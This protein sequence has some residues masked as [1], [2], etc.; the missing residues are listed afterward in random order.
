MRTCAP[1]TRAVRR[2]SRCPASGAASSSCR[3]T[4]CT[5]WPP[6]RAMPTRCTRCI[7]AKGRP[8]GMH[9][10]VLA[11]VVEQ[12]RALGVA[13]TPAARVLAR[14]WWPGPLTLA[15][16]FDPASERPAWLA[17]RDEVAVR[18]PDHD[19]LRSLLARTGVLVVT[20]ANP[21]GAPTPRTAARRGGEPRA[22]RR[23]GRR[24]RPA[25]GRPL[26]AGQRARARC[27]GGARGRDL[28][29]AEVAG[30][31][32]PRR[33][34]AGC[35]W[36]SRPRATRRPRPS[37]TTPSRCA[38]RWWRARS[39]CT[40]RSAASCPSWPAGPTSRRSPRSWSGPCA[41]PVSPGSD[42]AAV[43]VTSGPGLVGRAAGRHRDRQGAGAGLGR[44]RGRR[45]P[46]GGAPGQRV[47]G[48]P[49]RAVPPDRAARLGRALHADP[50]PAGRAATSCSARRSTTP[51]ARPTTRWPASSASAIRA[52]PVLDRLAAD[53]R[54]RARVPPPDARRGLR[55]LVL[56]PEDGGGQPRAGRPGLLRDGGGGVVRGRL[57]GRRC[58]PSSAGPSRSS[59]TPRWP[60]WA[61][62]RPAR[63][64]APGRRRWPTSSAPGC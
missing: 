10:P 46:P 18:I 16:G 35:C 54:G 22:V 28:A 24:R 1:T 38:R 29:R 25:D 61:G 19:F 56:R 44:A 52:G 9:L 43:A 34:D 36:P 8:E 63:S 4:P 31:A 15:F 45:Q 17:G 33:R 13:F 55:V 57:H 32:E 60:S 51:S 27:G 12:V 21:H 50:V 6:G 23:P 2:R 48:R 37:S 53:G 7:R 14:R 3:P 49:R 47:P 62:W 11:A 39:T 30:R 40:P 42:L 20:S 64:C 58:A 59:A 26:D 41:R 5:A